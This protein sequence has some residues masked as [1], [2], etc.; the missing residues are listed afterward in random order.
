MN[1]HVKLTITTLEGVVLDSYFV[2]V[3]ESDLTADTEI[4][5]TIVDRFDCAETIENLIELDAINA[6]L[7]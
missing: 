2:S 3:P 6:V 4:T 5:E 1:R 7:P